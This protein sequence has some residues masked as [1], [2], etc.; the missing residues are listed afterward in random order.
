LDLFV[1]RERE[2]ADLAAL[3]KRHRL[4]TVAGPAG[5]GKTRL[6]SAFVHRT[7]RSYRAGVFWVELASLSD[8]SLLESAVVAAAGA[9]VHGERLDDLLSEGHLRGPL[10][11]VLDNCEHL[12]DAVSD[13]VV[14][15]LS[16]SA[17]LRVL[18]TS[19]EAL[20]V[21]G[22]V[23]FNIDPFQP[24]PVDAQHLDS[25]H[26]ADAMRLF[27]DRARTAVYDAEFAGDAMV[28]AE[29]C[30]GLDCLPLAIELAARQIDVLPPELLLSRFN[31][32]LDLLSGGPRHAPDRQRSLRSAIEWSYGLLSKTEQAVFRRL[33]LLPGG[34]DRQTAAAV[35]ADLDLPPGELWSILT[36]LAA[37][38]LTAPDP[39][40][41]G[42]FRT[43]ESL[44]I[45]GLEQL[46]SHAER[47]STQQ[48][49]LAWLA[50]HA[51]QEASVVWVSSALDVRAR[52]VAERNNIVY[53]AEIAAKH[54]SD[55]YP[56]LASLLAT[57]WSASGEQRQA[58]SLLKELLAGALE[59]ELR[60]NL[61][62]RLSAVLSETGALADA[63][64]VA[65]EA[66]VLARNLGE[67][68][69]VLK[70]LNATIYA[71][72]HPDDAE[73]A[74]A[75]TKEQIGI[76]RRLGPPRALLI[77]LNNLAWFLLVR[78]DV[79]AADD[80]IREATELNG[81]DRFPEPHHTAGAIALTLGDA[82]SAQEHFTTAL[83]LSPE[84]HPEMVIESV[85][86]LA[87]VAATG[88]NPELT[89]C[90]LSATAKQKEERQWRSAPWW[91]E[92]L[93]SARRTATA[94]VPRSRAEAAVA[95]GAELT[96]AEAVGHAL[97]RPVSAEPPRAQDDVL[98][99]REREVVGLVAQGQTDRQI[100]ARMGMS[101]RTVANHLAHVRTKLDLP[102]RA[103]IASWLAQ[104]Q[105]SSSS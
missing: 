25:L 82:D 44:R 4:V 59:P 7:A 57:S 83:H 104:Q 75:L 45:F 40:A 98:T 55:R 100:A 60:V 20:L 9:G 46:D 63:K 96:I 61:L 78:G 62:C 88:E 74:T 101:V 103:A 92:Q 72:Q 5:V 17:S 2:L 6:T 32:R 89:L 48:L 13:L 87:I 80:A 69:L 18:A 37:K 3:V 102:S 91:E 39:A 84:D 33:A 73:A 66:L 22:E 29:L 58:G 19:R 50:D 43:L 12:V 15:L 68:N 14:R 93:D 70:A 26:Q 51:Q 53:A 1:G 31:E 27:R 38:S 71:H 64:P 99:P 95:R 42:R 11:L 49:L 81:E 10:L 41:Q 8:P 94:D 90:L 77:S 34:F 23:R 86:G 97:G 76:V 16:A 56:R 47:F 54:D 52:T 30:N 67:E 21:P 28:I 105:D 24:V 85:E 65:A 35:T 36:G 79:Q